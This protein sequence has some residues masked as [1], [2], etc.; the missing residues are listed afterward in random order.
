MLDLGEK[1]ECRPAT[2]VESRGKLKL[3]WLDATE[4]LCIC[5]NAT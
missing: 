2:F 5:H 1:P 4:P 3:S